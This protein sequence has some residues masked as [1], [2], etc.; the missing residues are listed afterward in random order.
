MDPLGL[1]QL[2]LSPHNNHKPDKRSFANTMQFTRKHGLTT[3]VY[4]HI[5]FAFISFHILTCYIVHKSVN[6]DL[7]NSVN[8]F[9]LF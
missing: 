4:A 2:D 6:F 1:E 8:M 7:P 9:G 5:A 3:F